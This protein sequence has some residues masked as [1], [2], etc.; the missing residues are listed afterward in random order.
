MSAPVSLW[1]QAISAVEPVV[2]VPGLVRKVVENRF[3]TDTRSS[4]PSYPRRG[5][6]G[7]PRA[8]R[9]GATRERR[10]TLGSHV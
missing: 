6:I 5:G 1:L 2:L 9:S 3:K 8:E 10:A 7:Q 4:S